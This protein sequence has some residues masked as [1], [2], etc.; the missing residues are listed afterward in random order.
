MDSIFL[1]GFSLRI[2]SDNPVEKVT[3]K[4]SNYFSLPHKSEYAIQLGNN[5]G[6][7]ADVHVWI[8]NEKIGVWRINAYGKIT[9]ERP[10]NINR[11]LVLL[12]EGTSVAREALIRDHDSSNGLVKVMFYPEKTYNDNI[13]WQNDCSYNSCDS[14]STPIKKSCGFHQMSNNST[15]SP[16]GTAL[17]DDSY[18]RFRKV[19]SLTTI[20][21]ENITT[22]YARLVVDDNVTARK[23]YMPLNQVNNSMSIPP[24]LYM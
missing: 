10:A 3:H 19:G 5:H 17:G 22:I 24:P 23:K 16:A 7:K 9:I 2:V 15:L 4:N 12:K 13:Y 18:Q 8:D 1:N 14:I 20:D 11:K 21:D 6:V